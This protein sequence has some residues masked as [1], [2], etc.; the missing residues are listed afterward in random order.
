MK[1][2]SIS[3][4]YKKVDRRESMGQKSEREVGELV[5]VWK[6]G[7][8]WLEKL[9]KMNTMNSKNECNL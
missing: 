5:S 7:D 4:T 9:R 8:N 6:A 3:S 2:Q 1:C